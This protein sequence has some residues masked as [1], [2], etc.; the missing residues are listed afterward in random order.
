[1]FGFEAQ[2]SFNSYMNW[3]YLWLQ[4]A[5]SANALLLRFEDENSRNDW[6]G[7]FAGAI[8]RASVKICNFLPSL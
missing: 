8:Y 2:A 3:F 7:R 5:E 6:Q 1:L 4:V